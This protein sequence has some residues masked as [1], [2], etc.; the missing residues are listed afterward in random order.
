ML[1]E[2]SP[3]DRIFVTCSSN[4]ARGCTHG[5]NRSRRYEAGAAPESKLPNGLIGAPARPGEDY[6]ILPN[7][8]S[9]TRLLVTIN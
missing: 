4:I 8:I 3:F 1:L 2:V 6:Q 5:V 9:I 7:Q